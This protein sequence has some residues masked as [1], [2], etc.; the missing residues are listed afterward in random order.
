M[1]FI[2]SFQSGIVTIIGYPISILTYNIFA[3]VS[4]RVRSF[5]DVYI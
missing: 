4:E 1:Y 2:F 5:E 3:E